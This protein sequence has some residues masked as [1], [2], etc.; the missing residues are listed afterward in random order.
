MTSD[1]TNFICFDLELNQPS[2]KIIQLGAIAG[3]IQTGEILE[4]L[5]AY[6]N[7]GEPLDPKIITLTGITVRWASSGSLKETQIFQSSLDGTPMSAG[8]SMR[9]RASLSGE[10]GSRL[11]HTS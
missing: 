9:A 2:E 6:I 5:S 3:N 8:A 7:P 4:S 10:S 11:C 1:V